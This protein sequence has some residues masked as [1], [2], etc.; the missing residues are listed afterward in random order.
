MRV[1]LTISCDY[2]PNWGIA[3][4]VREIIQN[5]I[6]ADVDGFK[7]DIKYSNEKLIV[8]STGV[9]LDE[10][11]LL[12]GKTSKLGRPD[13][14]GHFG[15]GLKIGILALIRSGAE[16]MINNPLKKQVWFPSIRLMKR[17]DEKVLS[18]D[19][20]DHEFDESDRDL[21]IIV[22]GISQ[23][24]WDTIRGNFLFLAD[25]K[26]TG[27]MTTP[28]GDVLDGVDFG[29]K[30]YISGIF[31]QKSQMVYGY[32]FKPNVMTIDRD[33]KMVNQYELEGLTTKMW[34]ALAANDDDQ[35]KLVEDLLKRNI[36]DVKDMVYGYNFSL[37]EKLKTR[38]IAEFGENAVPVYSQEQLKLLE[39]AGKRPI[40]LGEAF[41]RIVH[42]SM[43]GIDKIKQEASTTVLDDDIDLTVDEHVIL[44]KALSIVQKEATEPFNV[45]VVEFADKKIMGTCERS[46]KRVRISRQV[47]GSFRK[48]LET[49]VHEYAHAYGTDGEKSHIDHIEEIWS[50]IY[51][52]LYMK[53]ITKVAKDGVLQGD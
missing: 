31:V 50:S 15:E 51:E 37:K 52:K 40:L 49:L 53:H 27:V 38:F 19:I 28:Y 1:D 16:V 5:A 20:E 2:V 9:G 46:R 25:E 7:M 47:L 24:L 35:L 39:F 14:I 43:G 12:L 42:D 8:T 23:E 32:N 18:F 26:P 3:E 13:T 10:K 21:K 29:G 22:K 6:D 33:R 45:E 41:G 44:S 36:P 30:L 48:T 4:G 11:V 34:T 17:I